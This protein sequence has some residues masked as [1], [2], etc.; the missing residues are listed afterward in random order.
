M[1]TATTSSRGERTASAGRTARRAC[2]LSLVLA[3]AVTGLLLAAC[4]ATLPT[5]PPG[6]AGTITSLVPGDERPDSILVEGPAQVAG[7]AADKAQVTIDR[8]T[9]F[10]DASGKPGTASTIVA[11]TRVRVWFAGPV[12]ESYPVQGRAQDVQILG[13]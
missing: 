4:A 13:P 10:F 6:I 12:A 7:A 8:A 5:Q 2:R 11:G 9:L 3:L 1:P